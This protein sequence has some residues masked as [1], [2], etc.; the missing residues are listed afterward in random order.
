MALTRKFLKGMGLTDEQIDSVIDAHTETV[1]G[2]KEQINTFKADADRLKT[3]EKELSELKGGK[4]WKAEYDKEHKAFDDYKAEVAGKEKLSAKQAAFRRLLTD[5]NI[6]E[7]Y[8]DRIVRVTDFD[9]MELDG[10]KFK[11]EAEQKAAIK[12][13]WGEFVATTDTQGAH[14]STPPKT[15]TTPKTKAE[16]MAIKD[17]TERQRAIAE[18][19]EL[20][21]K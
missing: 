12:N 13:E 1:D 16:I 20:F 14:V 9:S 19:L 7:K 21:N 17:T 8:H 6:P 2:L 5:E 15:S 10:D 11:D 3:V 18:N 4:D